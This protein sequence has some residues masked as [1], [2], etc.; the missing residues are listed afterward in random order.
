L[1]MLGRGNFSK[2]I[3]ASRNSSLFGQSSSMSAIKVI[4]KEEVQN[5]EVLKSL[6]LE[7]DILKLSRS[8]FIPQL[9][10][11]FSDNEYYYIAM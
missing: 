6:K 5:K 7:K 10:G 3:L 9:H 4:R 11:A 2:V 8:P 1:S